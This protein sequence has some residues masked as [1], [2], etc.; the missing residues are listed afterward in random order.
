MA[1][2]L[3]KAFDIFEGFF[4]LRAIL[5][6]SLVNE[7][8]RLKSSAGLFCYKVRL[9]LIPQTAPALPEDAQ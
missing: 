2:K 9:S 1:I 4:F 5:F 6:E 3:R 8:D 7:R